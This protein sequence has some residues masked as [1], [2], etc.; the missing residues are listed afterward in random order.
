[1]SDY[2]LRDAA[3]A[4]VPVLARNRVLMFEDMWAW[5][6]D[7][8]DPAESARID[9]QSAPVFAEGLG[10]DQFGWVAERD[11]TVVATAM[12]TMQPWLPHPNYPDG[13]RCYYHSVY[14]EPEHR[15]H[16]LARRLTETAIDWARDRGCRVVVLHASE[17]GRPIY[18][19]LGFRQTNEWSLLLD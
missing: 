1:M 7:P 17:L 12:V 4:D 2:L 14:T 3:L 15:G 6:G 13:M 16:G 10:R 8:W 11:G 5:R 19:K 9:S 18:E